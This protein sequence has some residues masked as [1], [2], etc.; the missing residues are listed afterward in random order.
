MHGH[1]HTREQAFVDLEH[2]I[3]RHALEEEKVEQIGRTMLVVLQDCI[4]GLAYMHDH[5]MSLGVVPLRHALAFLKRSGKWRGVLCDFARVAKCAHV[6]PRVCVRLLCVCTLGSP[7]CS[8]IGQF[9]M[10]VMHVHPDVTRV[11]SMET[12]WA[13]ARACLGSGTTLRRPLAWCTCGT[14]LPALR[15]RPMRPPP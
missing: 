15:P 7:S 12:V 2:S 6:S 14:C 5:S 11:L 1:V 4:L 3:V 10:S 8:C 9:I 13:C